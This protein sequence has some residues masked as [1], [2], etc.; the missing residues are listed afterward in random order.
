M[1][2]RG[3]FKQSLSLR[4]TWSTYNSDD[5]AK[6]QE[7]ALSAA[8]SV[9]GMATVRDLI[10]QILVHFAHFQVHVHGSMSC[11]HCAHTPSFCILPPFTG[12]VKIAAHC[13]VIVSL[14]FNW[15]E[16]DTTEPSSDIS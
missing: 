2:L 16:P 11:W 8:K 10:S 15:D 9:N 1:Y 3:H 14:C 5:L 6:S 12:E 13:C 7:K 4:P